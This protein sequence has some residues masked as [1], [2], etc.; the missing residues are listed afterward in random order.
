MPARIN[1]IDY[2]QV[3]T[4]NDEFIE[5]RI[6]TAETPTELSLTL[7]NGANGSSYD[8][9]DLLSSPDV[10][11]TSLGGFTYYVWDPVG[12]NNLQNGAPDGIA[13]SQ[14]NSL[15]EFLSYEGSFTASGGIADGLASNPLIPNDNNSNE[16]S[17]Q[18]SDDGSSFV[19][20]ATLTPGAANL[21]FA[22]GTL[23]ATPDGETPVHMLQIGDVIKTASGGETEVLWIG[24]QK[25]EKRSANEHMQPVRIQAG[26]L[27]DGLPHGDLTVT[28]DHGMIIDGLVVNAN[29]IVNGTTIDWVPLSELSE[30]VTYYHVETQAHDIILANGAPSETFVDVADRAAFDNHD[31]YLELYGTERVIPEMD[32]LRISSQRLL[33]SQ[34]KL[35][36]GIVG[37]PPAFDKL[38][39]A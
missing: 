35:R 32:C 30:S 28:G 37:M 27:G 11:A 10:T 24:R 8:T 20:E 9:I 36:L 38:L 12:D 23:I 39:S 26:A 19:F 2:D 22:R 18:R 15:V 17:L 33:P 14:D 5:V 25:V 16:G 31:E 13:L 29:A 34:I 7:Y 6:P 1:E 21:C 3:S 4:D